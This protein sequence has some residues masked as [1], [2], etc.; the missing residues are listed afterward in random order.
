MKLVKVAVPIVALALAGCGSSVNSTE[1]TT[2]PET[3]SAPAYSAPATTAAPAP[4]P[5]ATKPEKISDPDI[6]EELRTVGV[7]VTKYTDIGKEDVDGITPALYDRIINAQDGV[8]RAIDDWHA[9]AD[10]IRASDLNVPGRLDGI[11]AYSKA[12]D[13]WYEQQKLGADIWK[14]CIDEEMKK[15]H[16]FGVEGCIVEDYDYEQEL[17]IFNEYLDT[18]KALAADVGLL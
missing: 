16:R 12:L 1:G 17:V 6:A 5:T 13:A 9:F 11:K 3:S 18:L 10:P 15:P 14:K 8:K 4:S 7:V 2:A